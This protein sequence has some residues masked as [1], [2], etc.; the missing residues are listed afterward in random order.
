M[1]YLSIVCL[2]LFL[3]ACY[4]ENSPE[5][6]LTQASSLDSEIPILRNLKEVL[7]PKAYTDQDTLLLDQLLGEDFL[8]VSADGKWTH[9]VDEIEWVQRNSYSNDSFFYEIKRLDVLENGTAILCGTGNVMND[10]I[11]SYY[12]SC[13]VLIKRGGTWKAVLSHVSGVREEK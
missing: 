4:R 7:W 10:S 11:W 5:L 6:Q 12:E 9:K 2:I 8:L 1:K 13:N 3:E